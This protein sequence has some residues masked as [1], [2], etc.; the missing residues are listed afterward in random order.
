MSVHASL[1]A[2]IATPQTRPFGRETCALFPAALDALI[3]AILARLFARLEQLLDL[4]RSGTL[5]VPAI[6][7]PDV[8]TPAAAPRPASARDR[9]RAR[10]D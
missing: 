6:R 8:R 3:T 4:C 5:P 1:G 9:P 7:Q 10:H 2:P